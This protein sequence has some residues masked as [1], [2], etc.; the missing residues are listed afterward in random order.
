ME[1][2]LNTWKDRRISIFPIEGLF[3]PILL[4]KHYWRTL[5]SA[6]KNT[7]PI[8]TKLENIALCTTLNISYEFQASPIAP[9][10]LFPL[11]GC[12]SN[13]IYC[14]VMNFERL[15]KLHFLTNSAQILICCN[16]W[17]S[18]QEMLMPLRIL[19][20]GSMTRFSAILPGV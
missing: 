7:Q 3:A 10:N 6:E 14:Y 20:K 18:L 19:T 5:R 15:W 9:S 11:K 4:H 2:N 16:D 8:I 13:F 1:G 17:Q 12:F